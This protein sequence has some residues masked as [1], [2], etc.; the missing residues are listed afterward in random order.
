[1]KIKEKITLTI[2][3]LV[4][5]PSAFIGLIAY[6]EAKG[7][8]ELQN[9]AER[10]FMEHLVKGN[11]KVQA[12]L[13]NTFHIFAA[14][15][16]D[17]NFDVA[18][19][20]FIEY[21]GTFVDIDEE[22]DE[23]VCETGK[24]FNDKYYDNDL[25]TDIKRIVKGNTSI[26]IREAD[27]TAKKISTTVTD[28]LYEYG[29][30]MEDVMYN[31]TIENEEIYSEYTKIEGEYK[32]KKCQSFN[33]SNGRPSAVL[34]V[35]IYEGDT[36]DRLLKKLEEV[37]FGNEGNIFVIG[38]QEGVNRGKIV[39]HEGHVGDTK[40]S[41]EYIENIL[42]E[43]DGFIK[44]NLNGVEK[45]ASFKYFEPYEWIIVAEQTFVDPN[46]SIKDIKNTILLS[47]LLFLLFATI[48][49]AIASSKISG[50]IKKLNEAGKKIANNNLNTEIPKIKTNDELKDL[51]ETLQILLDKIKSSKK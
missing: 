33:D 21:C 39:Y 47:T 11:V 30:I 22:N 9:E 31:T 20:K 23:L 10:E 28:G 40:P 25:V 41:G 15:N 45:I 14:D 19:D 6:N 34:C 42:N 12:D 17:V 50:P 24:K 51:S 13:V 2:I 16:I 37:S 18:V 43:K 32:T 4:F 38:N 27:N 8:L 49:G 29:Y 7:R 46:N 26:F 5:I 1:M 36:A 35:G 3:V 44:Y 48:I